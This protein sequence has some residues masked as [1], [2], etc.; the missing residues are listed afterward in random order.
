MAELQFQK[1]VLEGNYADVRGYETLMGAN[2]GKYHPTADLTRP[3]MRGS[4]RR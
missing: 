2:V 1:Q 3:E 4:T